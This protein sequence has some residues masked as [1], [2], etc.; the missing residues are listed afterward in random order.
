MLAN[1][2]TLASSL[3]ACLRWLDNKSSS[4]EGGVFLY[5]VVL[6]SL[7]WKRS[8]QVFKEIF[9]LFWFKVLYI[10]GKQGNSVLLY[11][12]KSRVMWIKQWCIPG[13]W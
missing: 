8:K 1:F 7:W 4:G 10:A 2:S 9:K 6:F 11:L 13:D 5:E 3:A 12:K